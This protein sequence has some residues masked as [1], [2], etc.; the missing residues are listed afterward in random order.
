MKIFAIS[1]LH[2]STAVEK[3]MDVFGTEWTGH[4]DKIKTDWNNKVSDEDLVLL[5][6]DTSWGSNLDEAEA[7]LIQLKEL[8][9]RKILLKGN[10]DYWWN[11]LSKI[12]S[13][14]PYLDFLQNNCFAFDDFIICGTRGWGIITENSPDEDKKIFER[15]LQRLELSIKSALEKRKNNQKL[16]AL[17]H[18]PPFD[19]DFKDTRVTNLIESY[20]I[21]KVLYGHLHGK[22]VRIKPSFVKN[23][24]EYILTS[25]DLIDFKLVEVKL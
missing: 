8:K 6:G 5:G 2:L 15:E 24:T 17:L 19:A 18:F 4:F 23:G 1:D 12:S 9:G 14:F 3:P 22:D 25:C 13:R 7:D 10:H 21:D 16:I 20:G 11:S